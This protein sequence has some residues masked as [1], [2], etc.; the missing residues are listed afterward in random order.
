V[1]PILDILFERQII[2]LNENTKSSKATETDPMAAA[3]SLVKSIFV[4]GDD[5]KR[6]F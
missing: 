1:P 4:K 2:N 6:F 3:E 5:A